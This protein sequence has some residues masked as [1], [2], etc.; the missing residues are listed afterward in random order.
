VPEN[1]AFTATPG[2]EK[3]TDPAAA[4]GAVRPTMRRPGAAPT[5]LSEAEPASGARTTDVS[6]LASAMPESEVGLGPASGWDPSVDASNAVVPESMPVPAPDPDPEPDE[7]DPEEL[8]DEPEPAPEPEPL[9]EDE[10]GGTDPLLD[11]EL[12]ASSPSAD[13]EAGEPEQAPAPKASAPRPNN[14]RT[15][16]TR[17]AIWKPIDRQKHGGVLPAQPIYFGDAID[18]SPTMSGRDRSPRAPRALR[19]SG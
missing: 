18:V 9:P 8:D 11:D 3:R 15:L 19:P 6:E 4:P 14:P 13:E 5:P 7:L 1:R 2:Q 10:P 17:D 12:P 16:E